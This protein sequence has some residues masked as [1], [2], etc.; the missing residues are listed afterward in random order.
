M[1]DW[2]IELMQAI[3]ETSISDQKVLHCLECAASILGFEYV[4][5]GFRASLPFSNAR[6]SWLGNF[7]E[8]WMQQRIDDRHVAPD[9]M[10]E[11]ACHSQCPLLWNDGS[12]ADNPALWRNAQQHGLNHGWSQSVLDD[13][14]GISVLSLA[15]SGPAISAEELDAK[16]HLMRWLA[17]VTHQVRSRLIRQRL[18][19]NLPNLTEREI[20]VLKWTADGKSAQDIADILTL[21]KRTV[22]FHIKNSVCKLNTPN[23]T[24]AVAR[25]VL[26]G[27]FWQP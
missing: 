6:F 5:H 22:D 7:P 18:A 23:K 21:S 4:C 14:A 15:R 19:S 10:L 1:D 16:Q 25:A 17:Q 9:A 8:S 20:E 3:D 27:L 13:P 26:L 12:C 2:Q 11:H 24:A